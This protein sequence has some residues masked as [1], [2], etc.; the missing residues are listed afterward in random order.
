MNKKG[1]ETS[2]VVTRRVY[3]QKAQNLCRGKEAFRKKKRRNTT[4]H[5][6]HEQHKNPRWYVGN[7]RKEAKSF[8]LL[9][10]R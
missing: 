5:E 4:G 2:V 3:L 6:S 10:T 7:K 1:R 8:G 9:N